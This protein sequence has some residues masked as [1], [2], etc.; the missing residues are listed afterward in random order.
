MINHDILISVKLCK[1]FNLQFQVQE[2]AYGNRK[3]W[4]LA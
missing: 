3:K 4:Q 1:K 2:P